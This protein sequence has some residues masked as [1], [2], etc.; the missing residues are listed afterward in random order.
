MAPTSTRVDMQAWT[1]HDL[2]SWGVDPAPGTQ[3]AAVSHVQGI[4]VLHLAPETMHQ[5]DD[6]LAVE[7]GS[8]GACRLIQLPGLQHKPLADAWAVSCRLRVRALYPSG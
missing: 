8:L 6:A 1:R 4:H 5:C 7:A 3:H 2:I